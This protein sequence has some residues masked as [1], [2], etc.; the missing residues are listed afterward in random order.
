MKS[1]LRQNLTQLCLSAWVLLAL[2]AVVQAQFDY[3]TNNGAITITGYTGSGGDVTIPATINGLPVTSIADLAFQ[4]SPLTSVMISDNVTNIG[5]ESFWGS[6]SLTNV[7]IGSGVTSIGIG[8]FVDCTNLTVITVAAMNPFYSSV[9]G[10]LFDK[11]QT[12]LI[13]YP[14]GLG[15]SYT[16]PNSVTSLAE[17]AF[18]QCYSLTNVI[19]DNSVTSIG[20]VAFDSSGLTSVLIPDSVTNIGGSAFAATRLTSVT[21]PNSVISIGNGAFSSCEILTNV[22]FGNSVTTIGDYAFADTRLTSVTTPDSVT[23]IGDEAFYYCNLTNLT[24][25]NRVINI[26]DYAFAGTSLASV[27]IPDSVTSIGNG[28]FYF[29]TV[30]NL[31]IGNHVTSIGDNAFESSYLTNV[32]IPDSVTSIG[33]ETF[34]DCASLKSV[35]LGQRISNIE[36]EAFRYCFSLTNVTIGNSLTNIGEGAFEETALTSVTIPDGVISIGDGAFDESDLASVI[37]PDSVISIGQGAFFGAS[38]TNVTIG[39]GVT[40]IGDRAFADCTN[41]TAITVTAM[42]PFY[43]SV[44]GV[45]FDKNQTTLIQHPGG[46]GGSYTIPQSVTTIGGAAFDDCYSLTNVTIGN[47]VT[48]IGESAFASS[49][50]TS[51]TIGNSVTNVGD[52]AFIFCLNLTS[53]FFTG[54]PP[55]FDGASP[56]TR[57]PFITFKYVSGD[58]V[59]GV[60]DPAT[61][62]YLPDATG[63]SN[64]FA[65]LPTVLWNPLIQT[66]DSSFGVRNHQFG[67]NVTWAS[68][69]TVLVEACTNFSNPIWLPVST[70]TLTGGTSYFSDPQWSNYP[71]RFYRLRSP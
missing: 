49:G 27:T 41:L 33:V 14:G 32:T 45:L 64:T 25:G 48:S 58:F 44:N 53:V 71:S 23:T 21:I 51:V 59:V 69:Q 15:G 19:I 1:N 34:Y 6:A 57:G 7:T 10:V 38:L 4:E 40:S 9:N 66:A 70:N 8:P 30:T 12:T 16:I 22:T 20:A 17:Q 24:I 3:T 13:Q 39:N 60:V 37:I 31:T 65:G 68:G 29:C 5:Y 47:S 63:W 67:F 52:G 55:A 42:N 61:V 46:L 54:N 11:H 62:Y 43:S 50:L 56:G 2:P 18:L 26:G 36:N 28:A 35:T